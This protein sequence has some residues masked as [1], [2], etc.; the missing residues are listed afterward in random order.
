MVEPA[1]QHGVNLYRPRVRKSTVGLTVASFMVRGEIWKDIWRQCTKGYAFIWKTQVLVL[2]ESGIHGCQVS[3]RNWII[4]LLVKYIA[5]WQ[6]ISGQGIVLMNSY[7][8]RSICCQGNKFLLVKYC[9]GRYFMSRHHMSS[10][11]PYV[12]HDAKCDSHFDD[13]RI[14]IAH[15]RWHLFYV[16]LPKFSWIAQWTHFMAFHKYFL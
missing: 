3:L 9:V 8:A 10:E 2:A 7:Q 15:A 4:C 16:Y 1:L 13:L 6:S 11:L 14:G 12:Y 5:N